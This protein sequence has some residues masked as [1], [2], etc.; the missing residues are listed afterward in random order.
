M[1]EPQLP[2]GAEP[3]SQPQTARGAAPEPKSFVLGEETL[4]Q[5]GQAAIR[6]FT[7][8]TSDAALED[9][10]RRVEAT[11]WPEPEL[12]RDQSQGVQ[13]ATMQKLADY[14]AREYDWRKC[15]A[16]LNAV[17]NFLTEI[18]GLD[19]HFIHVRSKHADALP[20]IVTHGWP[21]SVV[22]Q[23]KIVGPLTDPTAHGGS[24]ADAFHIVI[25]SLPGFGWSGKPTELGWDGTRTAR[26]WIELMRR[27]GYTRFVAQGGDWGALVTEQIGVIAPPEL[28]AIHTNMPS[29]V[30][31]EIFQAIPTRKA[32][33]GLTPDEQWAFERLDVFFN[34][35][36]GYAIEMSKRPQTLYGIEDSPIGL[37]AWFCDHDLKSY[38][39][40]ARV[41]DGAIEGL[42]RDDILDNITL[43]WLTR[44]GISSARLYWENK[45]PFFVPMGVK[46]PIAISAFPDELYQAPKS[47]VERAYPNLIHYNRLPK[48]GHFAAWEQPDYLTQEIRAGFRSLRT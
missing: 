13:L 30:P 28:L 46:V 39:L 45:L 41:F 31:P 7:I 43:A 32:P 40:K 24:A 34:D 21:G 37:A 48:G 18:D 44:T 3:Q 33:P 4:A 35:G 25:P 8:S 9:L 23:L 19:I 20:L 12:V 29:A 5:A 27:L 17:P 42:T 47:W 36:L 1:P 11:R 6:P 26:A 38:E 2:T 14:W 10:R 22:E 16:R 15:E